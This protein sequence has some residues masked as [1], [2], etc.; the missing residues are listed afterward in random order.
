MPRA[1]VTASFTRSVKSSSERALPPAD[2]VPALVLVADRAQHPGWREAHPLV[3]PYAR[4]VGERDD[5]DR[6]PETLQREAG[7]ERG[8]EAEGYAL[9]VVFGKHVR[10]HLDG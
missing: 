10:R 2:V 9:A 3:E 7:E 6:A 5:A 8:V 4:R 1:A